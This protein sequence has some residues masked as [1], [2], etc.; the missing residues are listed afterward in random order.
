MTAPIPGANPDHARTEGTNSRQLDASKE[1]RALW[2]F[3]R[4]EIEVSCRQ[5]INIMR[6][7]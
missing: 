4:E 2:T 3:G 7:E 1:R 5:S 6:V